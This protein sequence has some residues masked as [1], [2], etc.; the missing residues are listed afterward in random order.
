MLALVPGAALFLP[1]DVPFASARGPT[2]LRVT[3]LHLTSYDSMGIV[4]VRCAA[5]C[6]CAEQRVDAHVPD[7]RVSF[8]REWGFDA[9]THASQL[10]LLVALLTNETSSGG[11]KFKIRQ[12]NVQE[13]R[14]AAPSQ[15]E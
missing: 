9:T 8:Y 1:I 3:L 4:R 10:C 2:A 14:D 13:R 15:L 12:V 11:R 7:G 6:S 5:G